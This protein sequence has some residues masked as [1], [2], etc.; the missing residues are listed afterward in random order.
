[1]SINLKGATINV[2]HGTKKGVIKEEVVTQLKSGILR[3]KEGSEFHID[4]LYN[5]GKGKF[6]D[7]KGGAVKKAPA[8]KPAA[9]APRS[10]RPAPTAITMKELELKARK[11]NGI[12]IESFS[13]K[14]STITLADGSIVQ[15]SDV[16]RA[17]KGY[18]ADAVTLPAD[19]PSKK[20]AA[21]KKPDAKPAPDAKGGV[22][23][24]AKPAADENADA[25]FGA[26]YGPAGQ[27]NTSDVRGKVIDFDGEDHKVAKTFPSGRCVLEN[28]EEFQVDEVRK[29]NSGK[30]AVYSDDYIA[31]L[32]DLWEQANSKKKPAVE[33]EE[34]RELTTR[35]FK[36]NKTLIQVG[37]KMQTVAKV[38]TTG[39][40]ETSEGLRIAIADVVRQGSKLVYMTKATDTVKQGG[41]LPKK[42]EVPVQ[43]KR[44][45]EV[46]QFDDET[47]NDM[48]DMLRE[49]IRQWMAEEYDVTMVNA[50][51]GQGPDFSTF[52]F[53]FAVADSDPKQIAAFVKK[54]DAQ[55]AASATNSDFD[56]HQLSEQE[57]QE[58][59]EHEEEEQ[60]EEEEIP[61]EEEEV[62]DADFPADAVFETESEETSFPEDISEL[63]ET[64]VPRMAR[65]I[66]TPKF[67]K[68][69][70]GAAE[71][72]YGSQDVFDMFN[73]YIE[74]GHTV[75]IEEDVYML[76][77]LR[78][79]KAALINVERETLK[80]IDFDKLAAICEENGIEL[81]A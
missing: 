66:A 16:R 30:F 6:V 79:D 55:N 17:G 10:D 78:D 49:K 73:F 12:E 11:I 80:A 24:K 70:R 21:S 9:P 43:E 69:M 22:T 52:C 3:T 50:F 76:I 8:G 62:Q 1:M 15:L 44:I 2:N 75:T 7:L 36:K 74:P 64:A 48:R 20:P 47:C 19:K 59:E 57:E 31:E 40:I 27:Y 14:N 77:G 68:A 45:T 34:E 41:A 54:Q 53:A 18:A 58:E 81:Q 13:K 42:R 67:Q 25:D 51:V 61:E 32:K 39:V 4:D 72:W 28:G 33:E 60:E 46:A 71:A 38:F 5:R 29:T 35:D 65:T 26:L 56:Q 23:R 37:K 63:M